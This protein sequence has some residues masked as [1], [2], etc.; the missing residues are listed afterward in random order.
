MKV[1]NNQKW[2][3]SPYPGYLDSL[4]EPLGVDQAGNLQ[5]DS[6]EDWG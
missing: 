1:E 5:S 6:K 2:K 4:L 3:S